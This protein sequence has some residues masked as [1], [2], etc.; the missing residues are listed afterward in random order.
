MNLITLVAQLVS[1]LRTKLWKE[2]MKSKIVMLFK[3]WALFLII[4]IFGAE[5]FYFTKYLSNHL[6]FCSGSLY[7]KRFIFLMKMFILATVAMITEKLL[8]SYFHCNNC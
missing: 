5:A 3:F 7:L 2:V 8:F 1:I 4:Y 6:N